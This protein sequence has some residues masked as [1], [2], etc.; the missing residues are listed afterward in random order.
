MGEVNQPPIRWNRSRAGRAGRPRAFHCSLSPPCGRRSP[1]GW[2]LQRPETQLSGEARTKRT[3]TPTKPVPS[4]RPH[5]NQI[6]RER[7]SETDPAGF[8]AMHGWTRSLLAGCLQRFEKLDQIRLLPFGEPE[9]PH[10]VVV[11][12]HVEQGPRAA[13]VEIRRMLP[14]RAQRCRPVSGLQCA[15]RCIHRFL[16]LLARRVEKRH[17]GIG[18]DS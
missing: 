2:H 16:P 12:H 18:C 1:R 6:R 14:Q 8:S 10:S 11:V 7:L 5:W 9:H 17:P 13:V 3:N 15:A 4:R